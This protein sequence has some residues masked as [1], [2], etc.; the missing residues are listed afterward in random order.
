VGK[1]TTVAITRPQED[2]NADQNLLMA[3]LVHG[4]VGRDAEICRRHDSSAASQVMSVN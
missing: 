3:A 2:W 4:I 1:R